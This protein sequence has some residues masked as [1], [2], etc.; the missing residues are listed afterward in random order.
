MKKQKERA[1][2]YF[3]VFLVFMLICTIVSRGIYAWQMPQ[4]TLGTIDAN[5]LTRTIEADGTILTKEEVPVVTGAGFL[6]EKVCVVEGQKVEKGDV[7]FQVERSDL[8]KLLQQAD[9]QIQAEEKK[10]AELNASGNSAINRASQDL[11]DAAASADGDVARAQEAY[12]AA[13]ALRDSAPSE[14]EYK[15]K[16]YKQDAEYQSLYKA[17]QKKNATKK[18]KEAFRSY[19]ES[20]DARL[21][22]S[23]A[24]EKQA[25][26][27]AVAEKEQALREAD[28]SR[29]DSVKQAQRTLEDAKTGDGGAKL[30]QQNQIQLLKENRSGMLTLKQSEGKV[31]CSMSG[32]VS[33]ILVQAGERTGD[34]SAM[35]L[36]NADG[37]K[38]FQAV[39][40]GEEKSYVTPNDKMNI[41]FSGSAEQL[42]GI[43]IEAVGELADGS[44]Q[45]TGRLLNT[46]AQIGETG[47]MEIDKEIGRYSCTIPLSALHSQDNSDYVWIVEE[48]QT[49]L[50]TELTARKQKVKVIDRDESY[51]ALEEGSLT[52]DEKFIVESDKEIKDKARVRLTEE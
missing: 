11:K 37:E 30:E 22:E 38:L 41:S 7:L 29:S 24:Q 48:K 32:Y 50:G 35:V 21:S 3:A 14:E 17:S 6:V 4:V 28:K 23:Y 31:V 25:L 13:A 39:L 34:A 1:V 44:C 33:R 43:P 2:R 51:A 45:V 40:P 36:S 52:E 8:E 49:I 26:N 10:L 12:Q 18:E 47:K 20:L 42:F 16:A 5:T 15:Q 9:M 46:T 19:K 27:D